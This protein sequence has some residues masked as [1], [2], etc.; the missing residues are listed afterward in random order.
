MVSPLGTFTSPMTMSSAA[1]RPASC[2]GGSY[3]SSSTIPAARV[4]SSAS[5]VQCLGWRSIARMAL[6]IRFTVVSC[7]AIN[8]RLQVATIS[9]AGVGR[10]PPRPR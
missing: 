6:A 9:S 10:R 1:I 7:P 4:G 2:T 3:R 5:A 8:S